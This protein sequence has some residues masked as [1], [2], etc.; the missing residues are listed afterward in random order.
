MKSKLIRCLMLC[1][2]LLVWGACTPS[3]GDVEEVTLTL[4][5]ESEIVFAKE[6][7]EKSITVETNASSWTFMATGESWLSAT[8]EGNKVTFKATKNTENRVRKATVGFF[9]GSAQKTIKVSQTAA[10]LTLELSPQTVTFPA[11]GGER[12]VDIT[13]NTGDWELSVDESD[14]WVKLEVNKAKGFATIMV[15]KHDGEESRSAKVTAKSGSV[16]KEINIV[17]KG[18]LEYFLPLISPNANAYNVMRHEVE[19][20]GNIFG[21]SS[22]PAKPIYVFYST[23]FVFGEIQYMMTSKAA[24]MTEAIRMIPRDVKYILSDDFKRFLSAKGYEEDKTLTKGDVTSRHYKPIVM[25]PFSFTIIVES[26]SK[27]GVGQV[28][29]ETQPYQTRDIPTYDD[30]PYRHLAPMTEGHTKAQL[31]QWETTEGG[32]KEPRIHTNKW[33]GFQVYYFDPKDVSED[34]I[35][36][37]YYFTYNDKKP[38]DEGVCFE[39]TSYYKDYS[40]VF[41]E[42]AGLRALTK[43]FKALCAQK[44]FEYKG[45]SS[46]RFHVFANEAKNLEL[47]VKMQN[48]AD[49]NNGEI[50]LEVRFGKL[51]AGDGA[52][53]KGLSPEELHE[54]FGKK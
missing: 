34:R 30:I 19:V 5:D 10:D 29:V 54:L 23:S 6:G 15:E 13:A 16:Y 21:G 52:G 37:F 42:A 14:S 48:F 46:K 33:E 53:M 20:N 45:L 31:V 49:V 2:L 28:L 36:S 41:F 11:K 18:L 1:S 3:A 44:G 32:S 50:F 4:S 26:D 24:Q 27:K 47:Y 38:E 25:E 43:E 7:S 51:R 40:K 39:I 12:T 35:Q 22:G 8:R 17:Q 9:A